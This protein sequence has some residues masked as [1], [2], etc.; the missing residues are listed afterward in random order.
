MGRTG[1]TFSAIAG[2]SFI[3]VVLHLK[4]GRQDQPG[5]TIDEDLVYRALAAYWRLPYKKIDPLKLELK[6]SK[7]VP[8]V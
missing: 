7:K 2:I 6:L 4:L 5:K 3:D 1:E 8:E